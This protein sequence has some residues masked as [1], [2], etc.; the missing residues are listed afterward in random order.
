LT[1]PSSRQRIPRI[2]HVI[3]VGDESRRPDNCIGTWAKHHPDWTLKV[4]GNE[5]LATHGWINA[6]HMREMAKRELNGVADMMRWEI[7]YDQGGFFFDADS[8]CTRPLDDWLL[9]QEAFAGWEN[10][11]ARPG[12]IGTCALATVPE[13]P[14]IGQII[15][16][17]K[18]APSVVDRMAWQT[19]GPQRITDAYFK[20]RYTGLTILPSQFFMPHH[21][22]GVSYTGGGT[23]Y[24]GQEWGSTK[25]SYD[26]LHLKKVA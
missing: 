22:S 21:F 12:L 3:W 24:A 16:D 26:T 10:E 17:I 4:W 1:A 5:E 6:R 19:V 14:F 25:R 7:L 11:L 2:L 9:E 18:A 23:S 8:F 20:Y 15:Q 13:N